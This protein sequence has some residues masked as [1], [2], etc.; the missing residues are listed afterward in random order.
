MGTR[1]PAGS[2]EEGSLLCLQGRQAR[3]SVLLCPH[4]QLGAAEGTSAGGPARKVEAWREAPLRRGHRPPLPREPAA[5][6]GHTRLRARTLGPPRGW[7][8]LG[9]LSRVRSQSWMPHGDHPVHGG[10]RAG[11]A[12]V[13]EKVTRRLPEAL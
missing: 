8:T 2:Q 1:A 4:G 9:G 12:P 5:G 3:P 11:R 6:A 13:V 10:Q 7:E